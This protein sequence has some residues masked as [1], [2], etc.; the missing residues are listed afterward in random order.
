MKS[1]N[2]VQNVRRTKKPM[3]SS[4]EEKPGGHAGVV[5]GTE[6]EAAVKA[7]RSPTETHVDP[8]MTG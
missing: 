2:K 8:V 3:T 1:K 4:P 6:V 5:V 7:V